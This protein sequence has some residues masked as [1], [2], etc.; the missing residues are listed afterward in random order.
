MSSVP[1]AVPP[2][3]MLGVAAGPSTT[4]TRDSVD[5]EQALA[6]ALVARRP[7]AVE[8]A[9]RLLRPFVDRTLRRLLGPDRDHKD[10]VQEVFIRFFRTV[11]RLRDPEALRPFMFGIAARVVK[12][13]LRRRWLA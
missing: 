1:E 12:R 7:D 4:D 2:L 5:R 9:W 8:P 10:L 13:E 3:A 11:P 6:R